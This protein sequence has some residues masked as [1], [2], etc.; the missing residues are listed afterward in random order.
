MT[1]NLAARGEGVLFYSG[2]VTMRTTEAVV[3]A[4]TEGGFLAKIRY[5]C[6][7]G[8]RRTKWVRTD[9]LMGIDSSIKEIE[10][11]ERMMRP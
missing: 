4:R 2:W 9:Y 11:L 10:T 6:I 3:L 1:E 7:L 8:F 5:R